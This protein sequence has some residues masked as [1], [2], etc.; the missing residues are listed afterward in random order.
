MTESAT[1]CA[2]TLK[3]TALFSVLSEK[4]LERLAF[5]SVF[6]HFKKNQ[7]VFSEGQACNG[8]YAV[9]SG[10]VKI[11]KTS[12]RGREQILSI[13]GPGATLAELPVF[14]GGN[15]PA[16]AAAEVDSTL[17]FI[18]KKEFRALCLEHP[19]AALKVLSVLGK[20]LRQLVEIIE[21]LSFTTV[22]HRLAA[23]LL[24]EARLKGTPSPHG[25]EFTLAVNNQQLSAQIGTVRE[26]VSRTLSRLQ[27]DGIIRLEGKTVTVPD[28]KALEAE[29]EDTE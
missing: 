6:R 9:E 5:S 4:E 18:G 21:N 15:Y 10:S 7:T 13:E 14:D 20:R 27:A 25:T 29:S 22:R 11:F 19:E 28:L 3:K 16:S 24:R 17:I 26:L 12:A 2:L 8:L 1:R 23:L